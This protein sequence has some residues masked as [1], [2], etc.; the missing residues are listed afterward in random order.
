MEYVF[1]DKTGTLTENEMQFRECSINGLKY[2][3]INGKLVPEGPSPD[4]TEGEVPFLGS[5]SH[6]S[7][8]AHLTATSLRTS[9]ESE[10]ELVSNFQINHMDF[11]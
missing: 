3:E 7:T 4:S 2:Q 8:S 10:T 11:L 5:L 9:P 6:L 1:T